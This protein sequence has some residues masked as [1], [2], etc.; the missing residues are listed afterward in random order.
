[1]PNFR[2]HRFLTL[3]LFHPLVRKKGPADDKKIPIL[4]Y[5]SID[6]VLK[7]FKPDDANDL[8]Q[9]MLS[10]RNNKALRELCI[11]PRFVISTGGRNL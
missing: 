2:L 10:L 7:F 3:Y 5:H 1:M 11:T 4:M 8:V 6:S 9:C